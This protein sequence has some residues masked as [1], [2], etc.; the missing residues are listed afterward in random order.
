MKYSLK[1]SAR[2]LTR[3]KNDKT[4]F[5]VSGD[6]CSRKNVKYLKDGENFNRN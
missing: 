1:F 6:V 2:V 5:P 3:Q 4:G